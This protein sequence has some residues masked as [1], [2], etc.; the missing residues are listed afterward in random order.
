[1]KRKG[2]KPKEEI[3]R[4]TRREMAQ[5]RP[6][7]SYVR[8]REV[9]RTGAGPGAAA[10]GR[11]MAR[12][13]PFHDDPPHLSNTRDV[14]PSH[15]ASKPG[16]P[17]PPVRYVQPF[18]Q[19]SA[20]EISASTRPQTLVSPAQT[21][22][23]AGPSPKTLSY[24]IPTR[25][26]YVKRDVTELV[27]E[28]FYKDPS[29]TTGN[30]QGSSLPVRVRR[31][32]RTWREYEPSPVQRE[33]HF[34]QGGREGGQGGGGG[35]EHGGVSRGETAGDD[36]S[37]REGHKA[38]MPSDPCKEVAAK[39]SAS[40]NHVV[41]ATKAERNEVRFQSP[42]S[43]LPSNEGQ[44]HKDSG[45]RNCGYGLEL[46]SSK[47]ERAQQPLRKGYATA[48]TTVSR[49]IEQAVTHGSAPKITGS[50]PHIKSKSN[51]RTVVGSAHLPSKIVPEEAER[52]A[53]GTE[54]IAH[55]NETK[56]N[57]AQGGMR[58]TTKQNPRA[59]DKENAM[60]DVPESR[61]ASNIQIPVQQNQ[62]VVPQASLQVDRHSRNMQEANGEH[63][64]R[65][66]LGVRP[67]GS[68]SSHRSLISELHNR[69]QARENIQSGAE[70]TVDHEQR[71][72]TPPTHQVPPS[73]AAPHTVSGAGQ[74][75]RNPQYLATGLSN[76]ATVAGSPG[77]LLRRSFGT[78]RP[79]HE[80]RL[81]AR[82]IACR[83]PAPISLSENYWRQVARR[84][85]DFQRQRTAAGTDQ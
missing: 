76:G 72:K 61:R 69:P 3:V 71:F 21:G 14:L 59:M 17:R 45:C 10:T 16:P 64:M 26:K 4:G 55:E 40:R 44:I 77:N 57:Q 31:I 18:P 22:A 54:H 52:Q 42:A 63:V 67:R 58:S 9:E 29:S 74:L 24:Q 5:S 84:R 51:S 20:S 85:R 65:V 19:P 6:R 46:D 78:S 66:F 32:E 53:K 62:R 2:K 43:T 47:H 79:S 7:D 13:N 38:P 34:A 48:Q 56:K 12:Q 37:N 82:S 27:T 33:H 75:F 35:E 39:S 15:Q 30:S 49:P 73:W 25:A 23:G 60:V 68:T 50:A 11:E 81:I 36:G 80:G 1:M 83:D 8:E 70:S 28:T 41:P